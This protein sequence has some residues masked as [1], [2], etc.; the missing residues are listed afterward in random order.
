M[1]QRIQESP[2]NTGFSHIGAPRFEL[3]RP[4]TASIGAGRRAERLGRFPRPGP[5]RTYETSERG[6]SGSF[7]H[8]PEPGGLCCSWDVL[9]A[10]VPVK[11]Q[12]ARLLFQTDAFGASDLRLLNNECRRLVGIVVAHCNNPQC[13]VA[14]VHRVTRRPVR[15]RA[16]QL[17]RLSRLAVCSRA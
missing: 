6:A 8:S 13:L 14:E 16:T 10:R 1:R 3:V 15:H 11:E 9:A 5:D 4:V 17:R 12:A 7:G 2:A